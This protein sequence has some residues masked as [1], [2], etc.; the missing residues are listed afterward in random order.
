MAPEVAEVV[1]YSEDS[2]SPLTVSKPAAF[3]SGDLLIAVIWQHN[4]PSNQ[5]ELTTSA[6]WTLEGN[7]DGT[8]SDAKVFSH[9]YD[10]SDPSTWSFAYRATADVCLGLLRITGA[11]QAPV[12]AIT[13]TPT[14]STTSSMSS[15]SVNPGGEDDLL[16]T[17]LGAHGNGSAIVVTDPSGMT[18]L[19]QVQ[20]A[21]QFMGLAAAHEALVSSA[22]SGVRTWTSLSPTGQTG[23]TISI[24]VKSPASSDPLDPIV[25]A[26]PPPWLAMQIAQAQTRARYTEDGPA[27]PG[28]QTGTLVSGTLVTSGAA[29]KVASCNGRAGLGLSAA[30]TESRSD[31]Y[32]AEYFSSVQSDGLGNGSAITTARTYAGDRLI[33]A[34]T[35]SQ[36]TTP[37]TKPGGWNDITLPDNSSGT[38]FEVFL[39]ELINPAAQTTYTWTVTGGRR[40]IIGA[41]VRGASTT[42]LLDEAD[43]LE[44]A[45]STSHASPSVV[46]LG[47]NRAILAFNVLRGFPTSA[48]SQASGWLEYVQRV[49][50]DATTNMQVSL[51]ARTAPTATTYSDTFTC[52]TSEPAII[53]LLAA[54][55]ATGGAGATAENGNT[56]LAVTTAGTA[57]KIAAQ[58][59][60]CSTAFVG[61]ATST[62][63]AIAASSTT[64]AITNV[65]SETKKSINTGTSY[66][67]LV[68]IGTESKKSINTGTSYLTITAA[69]T[70]SPRQQTGRTTILLRQTSAEVKIAKPTG[71]V[72]AALRDVSTALKIAKSVGTST[73]ALTDTSIAVKKSIDSA[74]VTIAFTASGAETAGVARQQTGTSALALRNSATSVKILPTTATSVVPLRSA[75]TA[76]KISKSVGT[77]VIALRDAATALKKSVTVGNATLALTAVGA[78]TSGVTRAQSG[79]CAVSLRTSS[80]SL[81]TIGATGISTV[82]V[83]S[84]STPVKISK[85]AGFATIT[86]RNV[87][88]SQKTSKNVG[89]SS[90]AF[91]ANG[92][93]TSA[94]IRQQTG[95]TS[96]GLRSSATAAKKSIDAGSSSVGLR[97]TADVRKVAKPSCAASVILRTSSS[98]VKKVSRSGSAT[99]ALTVT[100]TVQVI[101]ANPDTVIRLSPGST[102]IRTGL[103]GTTI[104]YSPGA[105]LIRFAAT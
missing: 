8:I 51:Q 48:W 42:T 36:S 23:G 94:N 18:D 35:D 93:A 64:I 104:S 74:V 89:T 7:C 9:V 49:G 69:E 10:P 1:W 39:Y 28:T 40:T 96:A 58:N 27:P 71:T 95:T 45:S 92:Q 73:T 12:I 78:E 87:S 53:V 13:S 26:G 80:A 21:N 76:V 59:G 86:L 16:I 37:P 63:K 44:T 83:R 57:V 47:P 34:V 99:L 25:N 24:A 56:Q 32:I 100:F 65:G 105:T 20:V 6:D 55:P 31:V 22:P 52:A 102:T 14:A 50:G 88:T 61:N 77:S 19:S 66:L 81:K 72:T 17:L 82:P 75:A 11:D 62:K 5:S 97:C 33:V 84:T 30:G 98:T 41:L 46:T 29:V 15:P 38:N 3:T 101:M 91:V 43:S 79:S 85:T 103:D 2:A 70:A 54:I 4:N 67:A 68:D 90:T 60:R